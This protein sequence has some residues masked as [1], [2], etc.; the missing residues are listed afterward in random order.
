[1]GTVFQAERVDPEFIGVYLR[2]G[3]TDFCEVLLHR[4]NFGSR[5]GCGCLRGCCEL[6]EV[7]INVAAVNDSLPESPVHS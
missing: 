6:E 5:R 1:M 3:E 4:L 7:S 2:S